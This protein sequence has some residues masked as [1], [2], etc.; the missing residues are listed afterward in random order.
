LPSLSPKWSKTTPNSF[1]LLFSE[2]LPTKSTPTRAT[3]FLRSDFEPVFFRADFGVDTGETVR[4]VSGVVTM[5]GGS[6]MLKT[7]FS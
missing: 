7:L 6:G 1:C 2:E 3:L 5:G 4:E